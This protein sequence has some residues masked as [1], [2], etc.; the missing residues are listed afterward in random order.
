MSQKYVDPNALNENVIKTKQHVEAV[1]SALDSAKQN[2]MQ[3]TTLPVPDATWN[4]KV[5]QYTGT[6]TQNYT[7]GY[8][9][10][11]EVVPDTDPTE[12]RWIRQDVMKPID[13]DGTTVAYDQV[14]GV[15]SAIPATNSTKGIVQHGD[16]TEI[17]NDG[18]VNVVDRLVVT[19]TLPTADA[20]IVNA[21]RLYVGA[22]GTYELGG[23]YQCQETSTDVYEWVL[24]SMADVDLSAYQKTFLGTTAEWNAKTTAQ[25]I[26]YDEADITDDL[27][28]G[29]VVSTVP[30][31]G[32]HN[33]IESEA[34]WNIL[35]DVNDNSDA[36]ETIYNKLGSKNLLPNSAVTKTESGI[37][38]TVNSDGSVTANGTATTGISF[39]LESAFLLRKG[40]YILTDGVKNQ[41]YYA[42]IKNGGTVI[43]RG[44]D[45][46]AFTLTDDATLMG[47]IWISS[48]AVLSN[49]TFYPMVRLAEVKDTTYTPHAMTNR[50]LTRKVSFNKEI[51]VIPCIIRMTSNALPA[52]ETG[53]SAQDAT[54]IAKAFYSL[55]KRLGGETGVGYT[56]ILQW[57]F[58]KSSDGS[59]LGSSS[60]FARVYSAVTYTSMINNNSTARFR[61]TYE[62][63]GY[64]ESQ[65]F[66]LWGTLLSYNIYGR[67][68][69]TSLDYKGS[70]THNTISE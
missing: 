69:T 66:G 13:A 67:R 63:Y 3:F 8:F 20:S 33:P 51:N 4:D 12:Y 11:C 18:Q 42:T 70:Q 9:Y 48:G 19:A 36:I 29:I 45:D 6:T 34:V 2:V 23:I 41:S 15:L 22:S 65:A 53:I 56:F 49:V 38:F 50:E 27:G 54:D 59:N 16:G 47:E 1:R 7:K 26:E 52:W 25:K 21:V 10:S 39:V 57:Q 44:R 37:T 40:D 5:V 62:P 30:A 60:G 14:T 43:A 46:G 24:I 55:F 58:V 31:E 17:G 35:N 61:I 32:D 68:T 28:G 64:A